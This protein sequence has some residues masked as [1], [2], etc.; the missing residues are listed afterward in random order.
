MSTLTDRHV[1]VETPEHVALSYALAGP[2]SRFAAFLIDSAILIG[3]LLAIILTLILLVMSGL[4]G[5]L[6]PT[7]LA[8]VTVA[9][10]AIG[11]GYFVYFEGFREGQTPGKKR[12]GLRVVH[13]GGFPLTVRGA[14]IR[15][16][17]RIID[18]QPFPSW[19]AGGIFIVLHPRAQR[20]GDMA[21]G[22]IVVQE[23][24]AAALP[25][26]AGAG[27]PRLSDQEFDI[28]REYALR[29]EGL[30]RGART[31]VAD[32]LVAHF[33]PFAADLPQTRLLTAGTPG[34]SDALLGMVYSDENARRTAAGGR[35]GSGS[36]A[37]AGLLRRQRPRWAR[38]D[39]LLERARRSRLSSLS[40]DELSQFAALYREVA[41]D[42][43]RARTYGASP[44]LIYTLERAV[45]SGHNVLYSPPVR[46]ARRAWEWLAGG[47]PALVRRRALP[48]LLA[49]ALL[50]GP[51]AAAFIAIVDVPA[52]APLILPAEMIARAEDGA[53]R[54]ARGEGYIDVPEVFMPLFSSGIIANNVQVTFFAFAGGIV[55]GLGTTLILLLNGVMLGGVAGLFQ[56]E[57]L[58]VYLWSFVLPHGILELTAIC[59]AGGA[60][61]LLG[62]AFL[63][64]GRRTRRDALV[65]RGRDAVMLL[66]GTVVMLI[67]AGLIEGFISPSALPSAVKLG[68]GALMAFVMSA[69]LVLS[70]RDAEVA[71]EPA[72]ADRAA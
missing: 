64:P 10:F 60:G 30:E 23:E 44:E 9:M 25:E 8:I 6:L 58:S 7:T 67:L 14:V 13:E 52:R 42:L 59:I 62:S 36:P 1:E 65:H 39:A 68:F 4:P 29:R 15:N 69:Y 12:V 28:L 5:V 31:R 57:G 37:A 20:L 22:T 16:L 32:K 18:C 19:M 11:W 27:P 26:E 21:A 63:L 48:I 17:L 71:G 45:G 41:S 33:A 61:L 66:G 56:A 38:Y 70:G 43:A 46:S 24:R 50:Y 53:A 47:F 54:H 72:T 55:V 2:G 35:A 51:A 40:H 49:G 34:H 3:V